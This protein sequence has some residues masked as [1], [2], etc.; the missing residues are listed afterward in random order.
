MSREIEVPDL[1]MIRVALITEAVIHEARERIRSNALQGDARGVLKLVWRRIDS[2]DSKRVCEKH[3]IAW[4][5]LEPSM[6]HPD[7]IILWKHEGRRE[8]PDERFER[9]APILG[10]PVAVAALLRISEERVGG[11]ACANEG[12]ALIGTDDRQVCRSRTT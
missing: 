11:R 2:V 6:T 10:D 7:G 8:A 3:G 12:R 9:V 4:E 5:Q 1:Q